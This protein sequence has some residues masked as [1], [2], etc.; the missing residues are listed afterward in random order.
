MSS[1]AA[2]AI[3]KAAV[4]TAAAPASRGWAKASSRMYRPTQRNVTTM[5][6]TKLPNVCTRPPR[7]T[8]DLEDCTLGMYRMN[9]PR[10]G[11]ILRRILASKFRLNGFQKI[12]IAKHGR[13]ISLL[14]N[15]PA[16]ATWILPFDLTVGF[17]Q[18][19]AT[20]RWINAM[21]AFS[22]FHDHGPFLPSQERSDA[23]K[24]NCRPGSFYSDSQ[25]TI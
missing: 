17:H 6:P 11:S 3:M 1:M 19:S 18:N 10:I 9:P 2:S 12:K 7:K 21:P 4:M 22:E 15:A 13:R 24:G 16:G 20:T 14:H 23:R 8:R 25:R 5:N